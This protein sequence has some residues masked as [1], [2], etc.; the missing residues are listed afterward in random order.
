MQLDTCG[1]IGRCMQ[2]FSQLSWFCSSS[3][4]QFFTVLFLGCLGTFGMSWNVFGMSWN[5]MH[6]IWTK[7][8]WWSNDG[9]AKGHERDGNAIWKT[10]QLRIITCLFVA[11]SWN[12]VL[13]LSGTWTVMDFSWNL[14]SWSS[15]QVFG[16]LCTSLFFCVAVVLMLW[17]F[18]MGCWSLLFGLYLLK[19][20]NSSAQHVGYGKVSIT[21]SPALSKANPEFQNSWIPRGMLSTDATVQR[22]MDSAQLPRLC[23]TKLGW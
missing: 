14:L 7:V 6:L 21:E 18:S 11:C 3:C 15:V 2:Q 16:I 4:W 1:L 22:L 8:R 23:H 17:T 20:L 9:A 10:L 5:V 12:L 13:G 19:G